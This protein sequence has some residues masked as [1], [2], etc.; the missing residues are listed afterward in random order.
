M[1]KYSIHLFHIFVVGAFFIATALHYATAVPAMV[2]TVLGAI[3]ILYHGW[4]AYGNGWP[5]IN[6]F[7]MLIVGP[8]LVAFGQMRKPWMY[9]AFLALGAATIGYHGMRLVQKM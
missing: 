8:L 5:A 6:L 1:D 3:I 9:D 7:H 2:Y 4:R